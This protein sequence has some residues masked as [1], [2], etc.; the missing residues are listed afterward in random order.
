MAMPNDV[1]RQGV[2]NEPPPF[3]SVRYFKILLGARNTN[4]A[5]CKEIGRPRGVVHS[6]VYEKLEA[7]LQ[8]PAFPP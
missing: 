2:G 3:A 1:F 5:M 4:T 7:S 6:A 8:P